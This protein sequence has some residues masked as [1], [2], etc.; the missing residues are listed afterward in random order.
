MKNH[1]NVMFF[2]LMM[3]GILF[4]ILSYQSTLAKDILS[5]SKPLEEKLD[6][7][8]IENMI[9]PKEKE[10]YQPIRTQTL[11]LNYI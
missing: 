4:S 5:I 11:A 9:K 1:N 2:I 3:V 6:I 8:L 10:S 7:F